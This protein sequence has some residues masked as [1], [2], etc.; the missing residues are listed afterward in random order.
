MHPE[1][2]THCADFIRDTFS[3]N[4]LMSPHVLAESTRNFV[5]RALHETVT[6]GKEIPWPYV[7]TKDISRT[8]VD[9]FIKHH[10]LAPVVVASDKGTRTTVELNDLSS[11]TDYDAYDDKHFGT[12]WCDK[13]DNYVSVVAPAV[14]ELTE[15]HQTKTRAAKTKLTLCFNV[16]RWDVGEWALDASYKGQKKKGTK[17]EDDK[18]SASK[19]HR[20][21]KLLIWRRDE[22][23]VAKARPK[24][25][26]DDALVPASSEMQELRRVEQLR[27]ALWRLRSRLTSMAN[28]AAVKR[29]V[30]VKVADMEENLTKLE[31]KL[32]EVKATLANLTGCT[33]VGKCVCDKD[34]RELHLSL[35]ASVS[36]CVNELKLCRERLGKRARIEEIFGF[37]FHPSTKCA[38]CKSSPIVG[39]LYHCN[40]CEMDLCSQQRCLTS[41]PL[42]H[43]LVLVRSPAPESAAV[44]VASA[45]EQRWVVNSIIIWI[46]SPSRRKR[47]RSVHAST[48]TTYSGRERVLSLRG[49]L[50]IHCRTQRLLTVTTNSVIV[51]TKSDCAMS[52]GPGVAVY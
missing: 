16:F 4:A 2:H 25:K 43:K 7:V 1:D 40:E 29:R 24:K 11:F 12:V 20:L 23:A 28:L 9:S 33:C 32:E 21:T 34:K 37:T 49:S 51:E 14:L 39:W 41:H 30:K 52:R 17:K 48:S 8:S 38:C 10:G 45:K 15:C 35:S 44:M 18:F 36:L 31:V 6:K 47:V 46:A 22:D 5:V 26:N 50:L 27:D 42:D 19:A 13:S 3:N